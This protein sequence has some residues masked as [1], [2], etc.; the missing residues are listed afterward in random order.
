ML[1]CLG[2]E[3]ESPMR[4]HC[5]LTTVL[6]G[7]LNVFLSGNQTRVA[8]HDNHYTRYQLAEFHGSMKLNVNYKDTYYVKECHNTAD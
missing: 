3:P 6:H 7:M 1:P 2:I 4:Q 8:L 5:M